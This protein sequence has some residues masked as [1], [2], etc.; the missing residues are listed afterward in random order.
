MAE[1]ELA[2]DI[3]RRE[4]LAADGIRQTIALGQVEDDGPVD[5]VTRRG[6]SLPLT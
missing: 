1:G 3:R 2:I 5:A 4:T 6:Q